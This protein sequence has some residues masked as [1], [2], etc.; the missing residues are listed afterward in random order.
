MDQMRQA[1][2]G[3]AG[4]R[5]SQKEEEYKQ[6]EYERAQQMKQAQAAE[7]EQGMNWMAKAAQGAG[8]G[9]MFGPAGIGVGAGIGALAGIAGA[10]KGRM[11][12]GKGFGKALTSSL[13][14]VNAK[15]LADPRVAQG[16][17]Q[18]ASGL[19][20]HRAAAPG[21]LFGKA[22][23]AAGGPMTGAGSI[24]RGTGLQAG[25][26]NMGPQLATHAP[27]MAAGAT[28][29]GIAAPGIAANTDPKRAALIGQFAN[30]FR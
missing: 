22:A 27:M 16:A 21:G 14:D 20:M 11:D 1:L 6:L 13:G 23:G 12:E 25:L 17:M 29:P 18:A 7:R 2:V 5:Q 4:R 9:S 8:I 24:A 15:Y 10:V 3:L 19:A 28:A 26:Q 30:R